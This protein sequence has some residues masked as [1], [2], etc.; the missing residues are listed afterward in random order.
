M[1]TTN[2]S[3]QRFI[4]KFFAF[5][6]FIVDEDIARYVIFFYS[7]KKHILNNLRKHINFSMCFWAKFMYA[8]DSED[9]YNFL[10]ISINM[11]GHHLPGSSM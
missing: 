6:L 11:L 8:L 5:I 9:V 1:I 4:E 2:N 10:E 7:I 3:S